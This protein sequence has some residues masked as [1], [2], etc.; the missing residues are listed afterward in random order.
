MDK[1]SLACPKCGTQIEVAEVL[2]SQVELRLRQQ[3]NQKYVEEKAKLEERLNKQAEDKYRPELKDLKK[4]IEEK[5][6]QLKQIQQQ[7]LALGE[8]QRQLE[9]RELKLQE[10]IEKKFN[11]EKS[12]LET[13]IKKRAE[14]T[15]ALELRD[16]KN[17][18]QEKS[19]KLREAQGK[20]L[21]FRKRERELE[22]RGQKLL[23]EAQQRFIE[24]KAKLEEQVKKQAGE[25]YGLEVNALKK[26]LEEKANQLKQ[27]QRQELELC[28][29]QSQL[30]QR[31]FKLQEEIQQIVK[32]E[33]AQIESEIKKKAEEKFALELQD[34]KNQNQEKSE[35]LKEAQTKELEFR[36]RERELNER[37]HKIQEE[38][39]QK[40]IEQK[41]KLEEQVKKQV[42][43]NLA[44]E[45]NDLKSQVQETSK[46]LKIA[47][48]QELEL[49]KRERE[50]TQR[51][52]AT[53]LELA[54]TL[55]EEQNKI[56]NQATQK[57]AEE[58]RFKEAEKDKQLAD[59]RR[60]IEDLKQ[61]AE[62]GSQQLQGE[63]LEIE[64]ENLLRAKFP[65]DEIAPVP[66]G[67]RGADVIQHVNTQWG[68][69]CGSILW[70][71]KRTKTWN[72][73]WIQKLKD[74]QRDTK[75][76]FAVLVS[77]ALPNEIKNI[78][79]SGGVWVVDFA[80]VVG[81]AMVLRT[82]MIDVARTKSAM[83]GKSEKM[84]LVYNYLAGQEF[85]QR[86]EAIVESFVSMNEDLDAE[87]RAMEKSWAKRA[88]QI[89]RVIQ[90]T[91][92]LYGDLQ[93]VIG[94]ALPPIAKLELPTGFFAQ[95]ELSQENN[96][97][98]SG[99]ITRI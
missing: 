14:E 49:R 69:F 44:F 30:D 95:G 18:I 12:K 57:I 32:S 31:E 6:N 26:Q 8:L 98:S 54:R 51:E 64:L 58:H 56:W 50:L 65:Y 61:K 80:S 84:E 45:L 74:G 22:E 4:Q 1:P 60:Q 71:S 89:E 81:I 73:A 91:A 68:N 19:E 3:F 13:D 20:E 92:R 16:L 55:A 96:L 48:E 5:A 75:A 9:Q 23:E 53:K 40:F 33:K 85:R 72:E 94:N 27:I 39:R 25:E 21:V 17:Q 7:E 77:T 11:E 46:K 67:I 83:V 59:M 93:G 29:R 24:Q 37:E 36:K 79:N 41:T 62:S 28:E 78:G 70:E 34:L 66:K 63:I 82:G 88:K 90:S 42:E 97:V 87:K 35:K 99:N 86:I 15:F 2:A 10:E 76:N 38:A 43:D 52:Q 47:E